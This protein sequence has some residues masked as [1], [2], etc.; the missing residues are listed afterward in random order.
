LNHASPTN[1]IDRNANL[2][3]AG[4]AFLYFLLVWLPGIS[5]GYGYF[6]DEFYYLACADHLAFGYVDHPPLSIFILWA[7][8]AIIGDSLTAL[9]IVPALFGAVTVLLIGLMARRIGASFKGQ[10]LTAGAA[11]TVMVYQVLFSFYSMN[12]I[13]I[14]L[15]AVCFLVLIQIEQKNQP[16]LWLLFGLLVG[17][18]LENKHTFI[19]LPIGLGAGL[20]LTKGRR[21]LKSKWL[22]LGCAI[23]MVLLIPNLVWQLKHGWPSIEFYHNADLFKNV[24][25]PPLLVLAQQIFVMNPGTLLVWGAG[26]YYFML[27]KTGRNLRHLGWIYIVLLALML[28]AQKSR[29]DRIADAY[30]VLFAAGGVLLSRLWERAHLR[31]LKWVLPTIIVL[32]GAAFAPLGLTILSPSVTASYATKLGIV[33]PQIEKGEGKKTQLPQWMADRLGWEGFVED[34]KAVASEIDPTERKNAIILV[35]TYGQAGAIQLLGRNADLPPVYATQNSYFL[36]GP[37]PDS[38]SVAIVTG[39][40]SEEAVRQLFGDVTLARVHH[41]DWCMP[42]R[43]NVSIWLARMPKVPL[44]VVWPR[45]KNYN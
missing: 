11:M 2:V 30:L 38:I 13:S 6:I 41:C 33:V 19:L 3:L 21:H 5:R 43:K 24:T 45:M 12:A 44:R 26:L 23:S 28:V 29:P 39:P 18:G 31:W 8:R 1:Q 7:V 37:P 40:F 36:W 32:T 35:P 17:L 20:L 16:R 4:L 22:W 25:T 10:I 14:F 27:T 42:W 34:V 15:W 9:R